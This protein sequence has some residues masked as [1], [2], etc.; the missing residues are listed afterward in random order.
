MQ[1]ESDTPDL[2][3]GVYHE[4]DLKRT[5]ILLNH[6][7]RQVLVSLSKQIDKSDVGK[8]GIILGNDN[9]WN[10]YY[11]GEPGFTRPALDGSSP[12]FTIIFPLVSMWNRA[13][14]RPWSGLVFFNGFAP[15]GQE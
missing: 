4:Y 12:T 11:S 15:A 13:L 2:N 9:D 6:K 14:R 10:Y 1:R 7:G 3:T 5:L 8:K